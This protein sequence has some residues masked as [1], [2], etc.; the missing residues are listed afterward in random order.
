MS[1]IINIIKQ[2][3]NKDSTYTTELLVKYT[4]LLVRLSYINGK[5]DQD[6]HQ[7]LSMKFIELIYKFEI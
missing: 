3:K 1:D 6:L 2:A 4:P 7:Y 5:F